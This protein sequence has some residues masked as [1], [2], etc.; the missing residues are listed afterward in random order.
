MRRIETALPGV[1][2]I[3]LD[4]HRDSRGFFV[5][6]FRAERMAALGVRDTFVQ[7]NHSRSVRGTLRGM[8]WQWRRPQAKLLRVLSGAIFDVVVDV[9]RGSSTFARWLG[10]DMHGDDFRW[11]YVPHGFAHGFLVLSDAAEVEYKC[12][13]VYDPGGEAGL[14]WDDPLVAIRWPTDD[15]LL[16]ARDRSHPVLDPRREDLIAYP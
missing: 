7:D 10:T 4:V 16:S 9:R 11:I 8:H 3:E 12:S 14:P 6:Q 1:C 5:E 13:D 15:P 2:L